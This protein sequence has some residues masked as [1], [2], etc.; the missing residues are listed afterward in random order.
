MNNEEKKREI[1]ASYQEG[2][3]GMGER[4]A[5][6]ERFL[7][8][9]REMIY[10]M[11][12]ST[13]KAFERFKQVGQDTDREEI[14]ENRVVAGILASTFLRE[15]K[16]RKN[17]HKECGKSK[18]IPGY[19][20]KYSTTEMKILSQMNQTLRQMGGVFFTKE[21]AEIA[22][23]KSHVHLM[24]SRGTSL[25]YSAVVQRME[26][27]TALFGKIEDR[28]KSDY[29]QQKEVFLEQENRQARAEFLFEETEKIT[30]EEL[31]EVA[32]MVQQDLSRFGRNAEFCTLHVRRAIE[33]G[34]EDYLGVERIKAP[35]RQVFLDEFVQK[36]CTERLIPRLEEEKERLTRAA[37][38]WTE[39]RL[40]TYFVT[41]PRGWYRE[42][43]ACLSETDIIVASLY[44]RQKEK[45]QELIRVDQTISALFGEE[46]AVIGG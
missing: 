32:G 21:W 22:K 27:T 37:S 6:E 1:L 36:I 8:Q 5:N 43:L 13:Q 44:E 35:F 28:Q 9:A 20:P 41:E 30:D 4:L 40:I 25:M 46:E 31:R 39:E 14:N 19:K 3:K 18:K 24:M 33:L 2:T 34:I 16:E 23:E 45:D 15:E 42:A 11:Q 17:D 10:E 38:E 12:V 7:N 26:E 29:D